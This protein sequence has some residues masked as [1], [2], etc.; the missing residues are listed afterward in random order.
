MKAHEDARAIALT[1][2]YLSGIHEQLGKVRADQS[3]ED[4]RDIDSA[5]VYLEG[6]YDK[7]KVVLERHEPTIPHP[8]DITRS[9]ED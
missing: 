6:A 4:E 1:M 2:G 3:E 8:T 7:L 5:Q 9:E